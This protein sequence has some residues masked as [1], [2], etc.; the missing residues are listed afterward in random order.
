MNNNILAFPRPEIKPAAGEHANRRPQRM[1][2]IEL[3]LPVD[4]AEKIK[5]EAGMHGKSPGQWARD[6]LSTSL[7]MGLK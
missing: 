4:L 7:A 6:G 3:E 5:L 2:T 1:S